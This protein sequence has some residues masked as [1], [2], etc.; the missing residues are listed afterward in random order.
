M[1]TASSQLLQ[2]PDVDVRLSGEAAA[3]LQRLQAI[4]G[5]GP[6]QLIATALRRLEESIVAKSEPALQP[7]AARFVPPLP[8]CDS[9]YAA[10]SFPMRSGHA[11]QQHRRA[12][13]P[14]HMPRIF[15]VRERESRGDGGLGR[16]TDVDCGV[17]DGASRHLIPPALAAVAPLAER[18]RASPGDSSRACATALLS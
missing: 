11:M 18:I 16:P 17:S 2:P 8:D 15:V 1:D 13:E 12:V 4:T 9:R 6:D 10:G 7:V 3:S 5:S 14:V